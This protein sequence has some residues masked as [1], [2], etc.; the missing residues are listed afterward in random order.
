M[1]RE[2]A[3]C[4]TGYGA[5]LMAVY[6]I[7]RERAEAL[8]SNFG[9]TILSNPRD[10]MDM[11]LDAVFVCTP[12]DSHEDLALDAVSRGIAFLVEKPIATSH[13]A[14]L[15]VEE[16]LS[17]SSVVNAVGYMNRYRTSV[18]HAKTLLKGTRTLGLSGHWVCGA[19]GVPWWLD[20]R[21]SGGPL[22]EQATHLFDL[23]RFLLGEIESIE[24][25]CS[26][27]RGDSLPLGTS[28]A[29][30]FT[31]GALGAILYSCEGARKDMGLRIFT[32]AGSIALSG[33]DFRLMENTI[34]G[35]VPEQ[36]E[37]DVFAIETGVFLDAVRAGCGEGIA[38][39]WH[40]AMRTQLVVDRARLSAYGNQE[41]GG[42]LEE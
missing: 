34:D 22:N 21:S 18:R 9:S 39:T 40:D 13:N 6:D 20:T 26:P 41:S 42:A 36:R 14:T 16:A 33:W 24:A 4:A 25:F 12:P 23:C 17:A 32:S 29:L 30:R 27:S 37:E 8:S 38:S 28:A 19:Y 7:D 1:G 35:T 5:R 2:R 11:D 10:F 3:R 15:R 31:N